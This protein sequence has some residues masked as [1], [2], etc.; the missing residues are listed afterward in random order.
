MTTAQAPAAALARPRAERKT[1]VPLSRS[2]LRRGDTGRA[3]L[4][5]APFG[6]FYLAFLIG[7]TIYM[8]IASFFNTSMVRTDL[9]SFAGLANY[10]VYDDPAWY[11]GSGSTFEG[12]VGAELGLVQ[13]LVHTPA[14]ARQSITSQ[15]KVYLDTPSPL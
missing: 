15:L 1:A 8:I 10:A 6:I 9:G 4:F 12:I 13:Q 5:M 3:W 7:P 11:G 2:P 14:Q